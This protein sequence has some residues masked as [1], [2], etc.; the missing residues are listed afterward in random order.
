MR[1]YRDDLA[2][3]AALTVAW[4]I[5]LLVIG[6][7]GEFPLSDDWAYVQTTRGLLETG[8]FER[9]GWTWSPIISNV[10]IGASF[11]SVF[12]SSFEV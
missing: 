4:L 3:C 6:L 5:T 7:E 10:A 1:K 9:V 12:G 11:A 2:G 8:N